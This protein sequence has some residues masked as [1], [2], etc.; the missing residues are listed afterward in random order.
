MPKGCLCHLPLC[1][2]HT[3]TSTHVAT[4]IFHTFILTDE[5][6]KDVEELTEAKFASHLESQQHVSVCVC[7]CV[8]VSVSVYHKF[9]GSLG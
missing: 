7:V 4:L 8:S 9:E 6:C 3:S 5:H 2:D 1:H